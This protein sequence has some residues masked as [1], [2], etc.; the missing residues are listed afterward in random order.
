M[1][2]KVE[3]DEKN[4][5]IYLLCPDPRDRQVYYYKTQSTDVNYLIDWNA[6]LV[7][8]QQ[9]ADTIILHCKFNKVNF[10]IGNYNYK[11]IIAIYKPDSNGNFIRAWKGSNI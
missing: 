9:P 2:Y 1:R 6:D 4:N 7:E 11:H 3:I 5:S 8:V 10:M